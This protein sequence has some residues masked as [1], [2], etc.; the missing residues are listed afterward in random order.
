MTGLTPAE[1]AKL[2]VDVL[3][4][5][6]ARIQ[7][8]IQEGLSAL[9]RGD[10]VDGKEFFSRWRARISTAAQSFRKPYRG[11]RKA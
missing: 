6:R 7:A 2:P 9:D 1:Q 3:E 4:K 10:V 5:A 11:K 8:K